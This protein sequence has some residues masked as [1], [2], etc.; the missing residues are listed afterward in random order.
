VEYTPTPG[1]LQKQIKPVT[2]G[3][4]ISKEEDTTIRGLTQEGF[5]IEKPESEARIQ[6]IS[7]NLTPGIS[8]AVDSEAPA[9][10][11]GQAQPGEIDIEDIARKVYQEVRKN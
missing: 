10:E 9:N 7:S 3:G 4:I 8:R 5:Q 1:E 2:K 6:D 11:E